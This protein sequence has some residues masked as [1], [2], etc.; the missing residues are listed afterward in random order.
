MNNRFLV[1]GALA[2]AIVIMV[3]QTLSNTVIPWHMM[4]MREF[5]NNDAVVQTIRASAP[6]NGV[7]FSNQ[8]ILASVAMTPELT[9]KRSLLGYM[10]AKQFVINVMVGLLLGMFV[11][12]LRPTTAIGTAT[13]VAIAGLAAGVLT[14][15]SNW[16][17]YGFSLSWSLVNLADHAIQFFLAGLVLAAL[18][19]RFAPAGAGDRRAHV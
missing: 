17:W 7:Y 18:M 6:E 3:W 8:G 9:D 16:T 12:R 4:T 5:A 13:A 15:L 10:L 1:V 14:E 11:L 19:K 2:T